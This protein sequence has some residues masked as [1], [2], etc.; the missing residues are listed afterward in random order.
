MGCSRARA[1]FRF[2]LELFSLSAWSVDVVV[3]F[4]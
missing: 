2:R 3:R 4:P 1:R